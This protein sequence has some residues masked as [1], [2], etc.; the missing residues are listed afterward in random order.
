MYCVFV[1]RSFCPD[2]PELLIVSRTRS[3]LLIDFLW[4]CLYGFIH[5]TRVFVILFSICLPKSGRNTSYSD[6]LVV[7]HY[8]VMAQKESETD[9]SGISLHPRI[10]SSKYKSLNHTNIIGF[11]A[12][13]ESIF[14]IRKITDSRTKCLLI[15]SW[16]TASDVA[17][18]LNR[19]KYFREMGDHIT[20][21]NLKCLL[22]DYF[23]NP[24]CTLGK[25]NFGVYPA[26][27]SSQESALHKFC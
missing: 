22:W 26:T 13:A 15:I 19:A 1:R 18:F 17:N 27:R 7:F 3:V 2:G 24:C 23:S 21:N 14:A 6:G 8:R 9:W 25:G 20:Y 10:S 11:F 12:Q 5:Q 4:N 16:M